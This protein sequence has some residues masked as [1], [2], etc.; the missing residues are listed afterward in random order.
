MVKFINAGVDT[1]NTLSFGTKP[2][3][4]KAA[5]NALIKTAMNMYS[6]SWG[7]DDGGPILKN[8]RPV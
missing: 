6:Y 2:E 1:Q 7:N 8:S 4:I 3:Y 5:I